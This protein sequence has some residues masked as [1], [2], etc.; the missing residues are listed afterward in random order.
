VKGEN[1]GKSIVRVKCIE[2][3]Y[4]HLRHEIVIS[5]Q[6][7]FLIN[8]SQAVYII[9]SSTYNFGLISPSRETISIPKSYYKA[10]TTS[11]LFR[12]SDSLQVIAP[13]TEDQTTLK[14][15]DI[16]TTPS[17]SSDVTIYSK[18]PTSIGLK[19]DEYVIVG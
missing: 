2:P 14:V 6:E 1:P 8:P 11:K 9:A 15:E 16:R 7:R 13:P 12:V 19:V 18:Q 17:F 3:G 5:V 4:E 10:S